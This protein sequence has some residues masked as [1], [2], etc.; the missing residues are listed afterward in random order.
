MRYYVTIERNFG[1]SICIGDDIVIT[2]VGLKP[3]Q[4]RLGITAPADVNIVRDDAGP[5]RDCDADTNI[6]PEHRR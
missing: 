5:Q 2:V 1:E 6:Q 3:W 4:V